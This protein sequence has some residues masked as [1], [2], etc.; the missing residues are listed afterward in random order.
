[1]KNLSISLTLFTITLFLT[2]HCIN[3]YTISYCSTNI[4]FPTNFHKCFH[5]K[6]STTKF[7]ITVLEED[8]NEN[9]I[10]SYNEHSNLLT[11]LIKKMKEY[12]KTNSFNQNKNYHL[13]IRKDINTNKCYCNYENDEVI[14]VKIVEKPKNYIKV[15]YKNNNINSP[16]RF[17]QKDKYYDIYYEPLKNYSEDYILKV[18]NEKVPLYSNYINESNEIKLYNPNLIIN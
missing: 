6:N 11:V 3:A 15:T 2:S 10:P 12:E 16:Y 9:D 13:I 1:M 7:I 4:I 5:E 17:L 14:K 8:E 18:I